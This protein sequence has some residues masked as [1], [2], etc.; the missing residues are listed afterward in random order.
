MLRFPV[1]LYFV[2]LLLAIIAGASQCK[3]IIV[4][5]DFSLRPTI[6]FRRNVVDRG[7][8]D[9]VLGN[10]VDKLTIV[11]HFED[12]DGDLGLTSEDR[13][14]E[15]F[16][17]T[18]PDGTPNKYYFNYYASILRKVNGSF[19]RDEASVPYSGAF[20]PL[21][22]DGKPGPIEGELEYSILFPLLS[23]PPNDTVKFEIF[24][25]DRDLK[26]SN[27]ILTDEVVLNRR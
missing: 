11:I 13:Q 3:E 14:T 24:I 5:P 10:R 18:N 17:Q 4:G 6:E 25:I 27:T 16:Q 21:K 9:P 1:K 19:V 20:P 22:P 8:L 7:A 15:K 26:E 12:G 23:T 2:L